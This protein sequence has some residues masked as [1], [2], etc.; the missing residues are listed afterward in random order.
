VS[1]KF[2]NAFWR[3]N[4]PETLLKNSASYVHD[5]MHVDGGVKIVVKPVRVVVIMIAVEHLLLRS[6]CNADFGR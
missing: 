1:R 4:P 6:K 3:S 2:G 5:E